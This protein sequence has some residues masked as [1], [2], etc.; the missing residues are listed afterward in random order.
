MTDDSLTASFKAADVKVIE[1]ACLLE[2]IE[3]FNGNAN[4]A[5]DIINDWLAEIP[6]LVEQTKTAFESRDTSQVRR[7]THTVKSAAHSVGAKRLGDISEILQ[8][9]SAKKSLSDADTP[10]VHEYLDNAKQ[11]AQDLKQLKAHLQT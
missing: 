2:L 10:L 1:P 4:D 6:G 7:C 9:K 5:I 8:I 3:G 11:V